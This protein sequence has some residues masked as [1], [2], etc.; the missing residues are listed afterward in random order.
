[1]KHKHRTQITSQIALFDIKDELPTRQ[2]SVLG[3]LR[4][5]KSACNLDLATY[6]HLP[7][8]SI[9][10]RVYELREKNL[11]EKECV[12]KCPQTGKSA[13]YWKVS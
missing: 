13:I 11:V 3:A 8:N 2:A 5:L 4:M 10:P 9:T 12:R 1:M 7:I 6:L